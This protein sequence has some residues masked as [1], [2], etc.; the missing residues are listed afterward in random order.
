LLGL[1]ADLNWA[2]P[3]SGQTPLDIAERSGRSDVVTWLL[4]KGAIRGKK[5]G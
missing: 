1:G 3:W 5:N 4:E 2:A